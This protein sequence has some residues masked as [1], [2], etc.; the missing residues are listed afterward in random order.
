[1]LLTEA[2][3]RLLC[4]HHLAPAVLAGFYYGVTAQ[5]V[6]ELAFFPSVCTGCQEKE[7]PPAGGC[8]L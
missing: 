5:G 3:F 1:M 2:E 4:C 6:P 8:D 7:V